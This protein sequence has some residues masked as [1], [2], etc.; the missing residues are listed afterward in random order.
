MWT[1]RITSDPNALLDALNRQNKE[2]EQTFRA[3]RMTRLAQETEL[4]RA[5]DARERT[6]KDVT[7]PTILDNAEESGPSTPRPTSAGSGGAPVFGAVTER[8]PYKKAVGKK[9]DLSDQ[10]QHKM[11]NAHAMQAAGLNSKKYAWM[12]SRPAVP[13]PLAVGMAGGPAAG[14]KRKNTDRASSTNPPEGS[15]PATEAEASSIPEKHESR[16]ATKRRRGAAVAVSA[17]TTRRVVVSRDPRGIT[18]EVDDMRAVTMM[19][20]L[21]ALER[22]GMGKGMGSGD[23]IVRKAWAVGGIHAE[24]GGMVK[25]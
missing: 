19:D 6:T 1:H 22:D 17:P 24:P 3:S 7:L 20:V 15:S 16:R 5:K 11:M 21:F 18:K 8:K 4:Q 9:A 2:A 14:S 23:E 12:N 25:R 10:V 13:S